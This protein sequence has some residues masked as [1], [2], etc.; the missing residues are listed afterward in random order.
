MG[1][2][3]FLYHLCIC[4]SYLIQEV[5]IIEQDRRE[6]AETDRKVVSAVRL[7]REELQLLQEPTSYVGEVVKVSQLPRSPSCTPS[8]FHVVL[9]QS[10]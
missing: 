6:M 8:K 4:M 5:K 3:S 9:H 7:L 1:P 2:F 10:F